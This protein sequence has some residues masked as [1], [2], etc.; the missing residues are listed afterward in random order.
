MKIFSPKQLYE[1]DN[2]TIANNKISSTDLMEH[3]AT[4]VFVWMHQRLQGA[5]VKIHIFCGIGNNGGDGLVLARHL[6]QHGYNAET[7]VVNYSDK[8]SQDFLI[9]YD[10]IKELTKTWPTMISDAD[11]FPEVSSEDIIVDAVFGMGLNRPVADWLKHIIQ[12]INASGA[13]VLAIDVPSGMYCEKACD[14][15]DAIVYAHHVLTFQAPKL[16]FFLPETGRFIEQWE[17]LDIGLD[18][19]Y[20]GLA[21]VNSDLVTKQDILQLYRPRKKF[22]H[23]G[24]Y[25]HS[26]IIGGSYGKIGAVTL[27]S[28][29][30]LTA[31]AGLVT[32][33][34]PKCGYDIIQTA[35][36]E[37][38]VLT[39]E[40]EKFISNISHD[41]DPTV[42]GI[43]MGLG[44]DTKTQQAFVDLVT[45]NSVPLVIDADGINIFAK[46][47]NLLGKLPGQ[48]V[49]T[50]HKGELRRLI[51]DWKND[52]DMLEKVKKLS[53]E[54]DLVIVIKGAH[55][56]TVYKEHIY[57]NATGNPGMA[58]AGSGDVLAGI[59]TGL[60]SQ[61]YDAVEATV[62]AVYLH[63]SAGDIAINETSYQG[64]LAS[65]I[66]NHIGSA[67]MALFNVPE[68]EQQP[69]R[70]E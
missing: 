41:L 37:A 45:N 35:V 63:G 56:L 15:A 16:A 51:G 29:S 68:I 11:G 61:G 42:I 60:I 22:S 1:A 69:A 14:D 59:I 39:S 40:E 5:Q 67:F 8:R 26:L 3:A 52:F 65:D 13:Y 34:V 53:A 7:Y 47:K 55:T 36:P 44:T 33:Y 2:I 20:L 12:D 46:H 31:G 54:N 19:D 18:R 9:N 30:C 43:G 4:Q 6:I 66:I 57:V 25:G 58:T 48:T 27:A 62:L 28:R 21:E 50:P 64:L 49:L 32:A 70:E 17:A 10:R 38:M 23:K 24:D